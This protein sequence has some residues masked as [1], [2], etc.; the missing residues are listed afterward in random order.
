MTNTTYENEQ[1]KRAFFEQLKGGQGFAKSSVRAFAEAVSQWQM[2]T[3]NEDFSLYNKTKA[4]AF[5]EWLAS[6]KSKTVS[7]KVSLPTQYN[8]LRRIKRFFEW[9]SEQPSYKSKILKSDI[10]FLRLSKSDARIARSGTTKKM[11]VF[12]D[13]KKIIDCIKGTT[14]IDMR[15]KALISFAL[16]SGARISAIISLKM[17]SFDKQTRQ[18]DQNPGDGVRTKNSKRI[19][20]TFF[21]IG[22]DEPEQFFMEWYEYLEAKG[23]QS[24][25]PIF[26]A[27]LSSFAT[28]KNNYS[29]EAVSKNFWAGTSAARKVYEKRCLNAGVPYFHPHSFRHLV[30]NMLSKRRLTEEEK[31]AISLNL[32]HEN[33][34]TTF[35]AYGYG[36]MSNE[37]AVKIVQKLNDTADD[38]MGGRT[39]TAEEIAIIK[40]L[41][42]KN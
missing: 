3:N 41:M 16:M 29:K 37:D 39:L 22:W 21:P 2:F 4:V 42:D 13:F 1:I 5:T 34:A 8:Y 15:D 20:S 17:K 35:G 32:G 10:D 28:E 7:G 26:P 33:V 14:E 36:S 24:E 12:E 25:D 38:G 27:T 30:V 11:P 6:R 40:K 31:R 9:L 18:I 23:F 19:L